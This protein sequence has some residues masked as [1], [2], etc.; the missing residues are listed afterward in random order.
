MSRD[1][2]YQNLL[3][4]LREAAGRQRLVTPDEALRAAGLDAHQT[5]DLDALLERIAREEHAQ[6]R[7]LLPAVVIDPGRN[8]PT[9]RFF[10]VARELGV[11]RDGRR[12]R[13]FVAELNRMYAWWGWPR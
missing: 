3:R 4:V 5:D 10:R 12:L 7:P 2:E 9:E 11:F 6:G 13:F 8:F 1:E